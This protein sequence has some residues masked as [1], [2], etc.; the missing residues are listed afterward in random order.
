MPLDL[1][2][3]RKGE[4]VTATVPFD[5]GSNLTVAYI[6]PKE[7]KEI[8]EK[9]KE[10]VYEQYVLVNKVNR[11]KVY[12]AICHKALRG[13]TGIIID[14]DEIPFSKENIEWLCDNYTGFYEF[15]VKIAE[16]WVTIEA[17]RMAE[18]KKKLKPRSDTSPS[19]KE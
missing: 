14:G 18:A 2:A 6:S 15:V 8:R 12:L 9:C 17:Y 13:W 10:E 19:T 11:D 3:L 16:S 5:G 7:I 4:E 1:S